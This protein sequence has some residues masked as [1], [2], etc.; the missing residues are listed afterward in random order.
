[1]ADKDKIELTLSLES[2]HLDWLSEIIQDY[3]LPDESKA[4]RILLD[5]A[6]EDADKDEVF[7]PD[8]MRCKHC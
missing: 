3:D 8:N 7:S 6:I 1:M 5:Y 2:D 4:I